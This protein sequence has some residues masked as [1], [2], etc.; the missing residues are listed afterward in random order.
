MVGG[1]Y[2]WGSAVLAR[3]SGCVYYVCIKGQQ[4]SRFTTM[5]APAEATSGAPSLVDRLDAPAISHL[6][7]D[8]RDGFGVVSARL[9]A[10]PR[11][12]CD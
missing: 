1:C 3:G 11:A 2:S 12:R 9:T 5:R 7:P 8:G 10:D 6:Q 4:R